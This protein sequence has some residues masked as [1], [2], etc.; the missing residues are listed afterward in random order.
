MRNHLYAICSP[1]LGVLAQLFTMKKAIVEIREFKT[2]KNLVVTVKTS[3]AKVLHDL[4]LLMGALSY[5]GFDNSRW[6]AEYTGTCWWITLDAK[7]GK[8]S[9]LVHVFPSKIM[10]TIVFKSSCKKHLEVL[11]KRYSFPQKVPIKTRL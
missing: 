1:S 3:P 11:R 7:R 10:A 2:A 9:V 8:Q 4:A 5:C 6:V